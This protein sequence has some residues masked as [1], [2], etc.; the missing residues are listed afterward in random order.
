LSHVNDDL[1]A[2]LDGA[3]PAGRRAEVEAHVAACADCCAERDR[4]AGALLLLGR[5]PPPPEPS[6][7]FASR[8]E[9]RLDDE[10]APSGGLL[11]RLGTWRWRLAL[12]AGAVATLAA[13]ALLVVRQQRAEELAVADR[14]ELLEEYETIASV[15]DVETA[16]DA[17]V[18][19]SLDQLDPSRTGRP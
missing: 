4:L 1:S 7:W 16:E 5:L 6:P 3:L 10:Q 8:L 11:A 2:L 17:A 19:A 13:V 9:A 12:P 18:V 14:L 15:G